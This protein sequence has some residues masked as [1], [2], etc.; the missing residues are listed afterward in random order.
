MLTNKSETD[1]AGVPE[2]L[3]E[4]I[5]DIVPG[6]PA[7]EIEKPG[8]SAQVIGKAASLGAKLLIWLDASIYSMLAWWGSGTVKFLHFLFHVSVIVAL[9]GLCALF[10]HFDSGWAIAYAAGVTVVGA[11]VISIPLQFLLYA[12]EFSL[13]GNKEKLIGSFRDT[14]SRDIISYSEGV[15]TLRYKAGT[16]QL[17]VYHDQPRMYRCAYFW[18]LVAFFAGLEFIAHF[19]LVIRDYALGNRFGTFVLLPEDWVEFYKEVPVAKYSSF[20]PEHFTRRLEQVMKDYTGETFVLIPFGMMPGH[21]P[22]IDSVSTAY[23]QWSA[24]LAELQ[25]PKGD[26]VLAVRL[27]DK[28][29]FGRMLVVGHWMTLATLQKTNLLFHHFDIQS[30]LV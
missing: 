12:F 24:H 15:G 28:T 17:S 4:Q 3:I 25:R 8:F 27:D 20:V 5:N 10:G 23:A 1:F 6:K 7:V 14:V 9:T 19:L 29:K 30:V 2:Y 22:Q 13:M 11:I 26:P 18:P 16:Y 21:L